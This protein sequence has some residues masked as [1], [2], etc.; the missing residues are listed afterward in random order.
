MMVLWLLMLR[1]IAIEFRSHVES[2]IWKPFWDAIFCGASALLAL[3][4]G[5]A[6]ATSSAACRSRRTIFLS[7]ALWTDFRVRPSPGILDWYT[8][9]TGLLALATLTAHGAHYIALKTEGAL[10]V[11]ARHVAERGW[12]AVVTLTVL[13]SFATVYVRPHIVDNFR[14]Y[15]WGWLIPIL[16]ATS[17]I[18]MRACRAKSFD[19]AAFFSS[20]AYITGMLGGAA[21]ALYPILL[22]ASTDPAYSLTIHNAKTGAYSL[23]IGLIWWLIG[24]TLAVGYFIFLYR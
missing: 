3:F 15:P 2:A 18:A 5:A 14:S 16:V 13:T 6:S 4:F 7:A 24:I 1:G 12:W 17:L 21:F 22:P 11:R 9:L 23:S 19:K 10:C 20:A 8:T